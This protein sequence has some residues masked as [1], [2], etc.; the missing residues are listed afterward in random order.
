MAYAHVK[1]K[2]DKDE[3]YTTISSPHWNRGA[4]E[5]ANDL[6]LMAS[7]LA[8]MGMSLEVR[9]IHEGR[10]GIALEAGE[11]AARKRL[12]YKAQ[13][14]DSFIKALSKLTSGYPE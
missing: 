13:L 5:F 2:Y 14:A 12:E 3:H 11:E 8:E 1:I 6:R 7:R 9:S 10:D 4:L